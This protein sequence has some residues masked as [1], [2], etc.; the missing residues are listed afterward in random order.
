MNNKV[1]NKKSEIRIGLIPLYLKL[2]DDIDPNLRH[3]FSALI[4]SIKTELSRNG[5]V[6]VSQIITNESEVN[7]LIDDFKS[8][9]VEVVVT[10]HLS[11]SPSMLI[12]GALKRLNKPVIIISTSLSRSFSEMSEKFLLQNHGIHGVMDLASVLQHMGIHYQIVSGYFLDHTFNTDLTNSILIVKAV[13]EFKNQNI[14]LTGIP[15]KMMG[16][17]NIS[18]SYLNN[19]FGIKKFRIREETILRKQS[20]I[21]DKQIQDLVDEDNLL[22]DID[23]FY[24]DTHKISVGNY[25]ALKRIMEENN[26]SAYTMNYLDFKDSQVPFY[27][28]NRLMSEGYGYAGEGDV[29]TASLGSPFNVLSE[30]AMFTEF[31]CPDWEKN[32]IIM[33]HMGEIDPRFACSEARGRLVEKKALGSKFHSIY[34]RFIFQNTTLTF[35][36]FSKTQET[37]LKLVI[38][39]L[40]TVDLKLFDCFEAPHFVVK[41]TMPLPDF[42]RKYSI[43]GGGHHLYVAESNI[44]NKIRVWAQILGIPVDLI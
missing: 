3:T 39:L 41:P 21:T 20:E 17:F 12:V 1:K 16:D 43:S 6:I 42:F 7:D 34:H 10:L 13:A 23:F 4:S 37:G 14:G 31:F 19:R 35:A 9:S 15:F 44:I 29:L 24:E 5:Y 22:Y 18:F 36:A 28:V 40:D 8:K 38:G 32:N 27:A 11:Y 30:K 33:S 26:L 2:Y 25:L